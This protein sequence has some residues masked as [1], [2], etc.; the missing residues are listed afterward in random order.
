[1]GKFIALVLCAVLLLFAFQSMKQQQARDKVTR[2]EAAERGATSVSSLSQSG[3]AYLVKGAD[4]QNIAADLI[5]KQITYRGTIAEI[6]RFPSDTVLVLSED[7]CYYLIVPWGSLGDVPDDFKNQLDKNGLQPGDKI[8]LTGTVE[9][10]MQE[11]GV[12]KSILRFKSC[13]L[14]PVASWER[15]W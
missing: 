12:N 7:E 11:H 1:M 14:K 6:K 2:Q 5:D 3:G 9:R 13:F 4:M 10:L 8:T 15:G